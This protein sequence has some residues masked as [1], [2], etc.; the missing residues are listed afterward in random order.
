M[1][2]KDEE[3]D[4]QRVQLKESIIHTSLHARVQALS[5]TDACAR[6]TRKVLA[7]QRGQHYCTCLNELE[8]TN[9]E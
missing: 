1:L 2:F 7:S 9:R 8:K 4:A 3:V 6:H 5:L